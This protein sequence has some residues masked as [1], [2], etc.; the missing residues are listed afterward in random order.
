MILTHDGSIH[1]VR[2]VPQEEAQ[3]RE[4]AAAAQHRARHI[5]GSVLVV[6]AL[7]EQAAREV[8]YADDLTR[9]WSEKA[10][11]AAHA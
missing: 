1:L 10:W 11:E 2:H 6:A 5:R 7:D 8:A 4:P 9:A 3:R